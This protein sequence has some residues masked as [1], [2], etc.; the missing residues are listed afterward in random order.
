[1]RATAAD[2][3]DRFAAL[4]GATTDGPVVTKLIDCPVG[5]LVVAATD[6][7]L[8]MLEFSD[9]KRIAPQAKAL[10]RHLGPSRIGSHRFI[11][12]TEAELAEY[13]AGTRRVFE[14]PL[15]I[16]GTEFQEAVWRLLL[17]IPYAER[18]AY[19]DLAE[20]LGRPG[21]QRAV[22]HANG[23]NR[24]AIIVPCH[25]VVNRDGGLCGYG[26]G[27]WRKKILLDHER[28]TA[29]PD[30]LDGTPLAGMRAG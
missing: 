10:A 7:G 9:E 29:F 1:M 8:A 22:G 20:R 26:G 12:Q 18:V 15:V 4:I 14:V 28:L 30:A 11:E 17:E 16:K 25:R 6:R 3:L 5:P 23:Q 2:L 19:T 21:S 24:I 13:F 27:L